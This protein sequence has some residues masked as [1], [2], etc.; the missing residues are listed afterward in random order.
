MR[1]LRSPVIVG[2]IAGILASTTG[3]C[4]LRTGPAPDIEIC[5]DCVEPAP[6]AP[7]PLLPPASA[8]AG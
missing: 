2:A 5:Q 4:V 7:T 1:T 6:L 8:D 3:Y